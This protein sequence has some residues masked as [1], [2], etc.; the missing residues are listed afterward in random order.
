MK[1]NH[2]WCIFQ[3]LFSCHLKKATTFMVHAILLEVYCI[4]APPVLRFEHGQ[5]HEVLHHHLHQRHTSKS[6]LAED[7]SSAVTSSLS[8][9]SRLSHHFQSSSKDLCNSTVGNIGILAGNRNL[10]FLWLTKHGH[11]HRFALPDS[12]YHSL[13]HSCRGL[14]MEQH[15]VLPRIRHTHMVHLKV[16]VRNIYFIFDS[17]EYFA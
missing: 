9:W 10:M 2:I 4:Q 15:W 13:H 17:I 7:E 16:F 1:E 6:M 14:L 12:M 5:G 3:C 11:W 8:H